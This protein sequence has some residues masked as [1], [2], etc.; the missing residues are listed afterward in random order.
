MAQHLIWHESPSKH[1]EKY[2]QDMLYQEAVISFDL[3]AHQMYPNVTTS[4]G[5]LQHKIYEN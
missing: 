5:Y 3:E 1:F 4:Y 2:S